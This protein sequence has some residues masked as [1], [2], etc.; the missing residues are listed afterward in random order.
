MPEIVIENPFVVARLS[1]PG[2]QGD[3]LKPHAGLRE[4]PPQAISGGSR[5]STGQARISMRNKLH[6][7][8]DGSVLSPCQAGHSCR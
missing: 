8:Q 1:R 6:R 7:G 5:P 4:L 2:V 3:G